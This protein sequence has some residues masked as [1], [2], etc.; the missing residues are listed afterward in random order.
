M[1][2]AAVIALPTGA[3]WA[4]DLQAQPK[5]GDPVAGLTADELDRFFLGMDEFNRTFEAEEG[6]GPIFNQDSCGSCHNN[7]VG[8]PG[9]VRVLRAGLLIK[10]NFDP[11]EE[12]GGSLFQLEAINEDC[13][14]DPHESA[15]IFA[16]RITNGM[17]GYG[18][19]QAIPG[20]DIVANADPDDLNGDGI[21]GRVHMVAAAEDPPKAPLRVGRFGWKAQVAT[22]TTFS[23]G[24]ALNEIGITSPLAPDDNDPNGINPPELADCDDVPDPEIGMEYI[25]ALTDFQ[26]F[27]AAPP[28]T[29][30]SGMTGEI[31]FNDIGCADCHIAEFVTADDPKLEDAIRNKTI[32]PYS[33]FLLHDAGGAADFIADGDA[34][35]G[36]I[37]TPPLAGLRRRDPVWHDGRFEAGTFEDRMDLAIAEH[38]AV[39]AE[40]VDSFLAY[41]ALGDDDTASLFA[42]LDSL[43]RAEF[44]AD[45]D[46]VIN[47]EDFGDFLQCVDADIIPD[48]PCAVHDVD[49]D[50]DA[51]IDDLNILITVYED[52]QGDCNDNGVNDLIDIF[53]GTS[54]DEDGNGIPDECRDIPGDVDGDGDVDTTD[55]ILLL[56]AWGACDDCE[57]CVADFDDDCFVGTSDLIILLGNWG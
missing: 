42:F 52:E 45:G 25:D 4:G 31:I 30:K 48:D 9:T 29:P 27:L 53:D 33:D 38:G 5:M 17:L 2:V 51:D 6:L 20:D 8:G 49:Q 3:A 36:E 26:R 39:G 46:D 23:A 14:E 24:A 50:G 35:I 11:L 43:G 13:G 28:Q 56:G 15:N 54:L 32:R 12:F 44:D 21:S 18:L 10:G 40:S 16:E 41:E 1:S 19:V 55:L 37:K 7:P 34:G 57:N 47:A 22:M